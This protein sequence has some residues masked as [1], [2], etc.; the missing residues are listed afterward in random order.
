MHLKS[1]AVTNVAMLHDNI[2][3]IVAIVHWKTVAF[4]N[5]S[6]L[7]SHTLRIVAFFLMKTATVLKYHGTHFLKIFQINN[8]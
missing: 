6:G 2:S 7:P 8:R 4:V 5:E 1:Q 3:T